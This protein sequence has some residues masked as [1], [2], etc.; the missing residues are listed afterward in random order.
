MQG[1]Q[2]VSMASIYKNPFDDYNANVLTPDLILQ[3]WYTPFK[4]GALKDFDESVF[5][6]EKMPVILQGSRGSGKTTILK[7]FSFPVQLERAQQSDLSICQQIQRDGGVGFYLRCDDSFL[8]MFKTVFKYTM[9]DVWY[10]CFKHYLELFFS[11]NILLM[12]QKIG[13]GDSK[14]ETDFVKSLSLEQYDKD[15]SFSSTKDILDYLD[16]EIRYLNKYKN[17]AL[18]TNA[19]FKPQHIWGFYELS[20]MLIASIRVFFK[21]F[22]NINF[23]LLIDEFEN[24][25]TELQEMFNTI[26]KFCDSGMSLRIGRRSENVVTT[27]TINNVEYL[28]EGSDYR[29]I[30]LDYQGTEIQE[31]KPYLA[32]IAQ[33]RLE[34]LEGI[35]LPHDII[36]IL[37]EKENLD[38]E[39]Q[40]VVCGKN[41]HL[42]EILRTN[43]R[44][45]SNESLCEDIINIISGKNVIATALCAL[46]IAR[47]N[48]DD[49]KS[50]AIDSA[51]AMSAFF[52]KKDHPRFEKFK[53][54][55][56]NK[57]RYALTCLIC[58]IYKKDK[59]YYSF[60]TICYLS[61]GNTRTFI[62]LV[63]AVMS[64]A[65]FYEKKSFLI[66]GKISPI[67]QSRA[68]KAFSIAE[69]NSVCS[70]IQDG[71]AI[72]NLI[73]RIGEVLAEYHKDKLVRY[74]ETIQFTYNSEELS[75][76]GKTVIKT[77]EGWAL[78]RRRKEKQ[79]LSAGINQEDY[80]WALN[81]VFSPIFNISYRIRGGINVIFSADDIDN[82][83]CGSHISK[84]QSCR[85]NVLNGASAETAGEVNKSVVM[86][87]LS[88]FDRGEDQ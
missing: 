87:Q 26:I 18:F 15:F 76:L 16:S 52:E 31:L 49:L 58:T 8:G 40:R 44:I 70:I 14:E 30:V 79:R 41:R 54:D 83:I 3:Y 34:A 65:M 43:P 32:G 71:K 21:F 10:E 29:L 88:L 36:Q 35:T 24:L 73:L 81:R 42:Y 82:M 5:F 61:E 33:K 9:K 47:S 23:L 84:L 57:Y 25:P 6:T 2:N 48:E 11:K 38:E 77:A 55:Y 68:V 50:Y 46:W 45:R 7:Y 80:L 12:T 72:K 74:P 1:L 22:N 37:G 28:R 78:I 27:A 4:T 17:E 62:N 20:K 63:K 67:S 56:T 85:N 51:S 53:N 19:E 66:S 75:N 69:F 86:E 13:F 64:D 59:S 60:N 39:C